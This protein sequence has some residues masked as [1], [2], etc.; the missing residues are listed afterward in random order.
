LRQTYWKD[1]GIVDLRISDGGIA[2]FAVPSKPE[3]WTETA[4]ALFSNNQFSDAFDGYQKAHMYREAAIAHAHHLEQESRQIPHRRASHRIR[5]FVKA[6]EAFL[7]CASGQTS[8]DE[9]T[10]FLRRAGQCFV[11][12]KKHDLAAKAY[13]DALMF[14]EAVS[15]Y[16]LAHML[17]KAMAIIRARRD[18]IKDDIAEGVIETARYAWTSDQKFEYVQDTF[19]V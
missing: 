17:D 13:A 14:T 3:D 8:P 19:V 4:E 18:S 12:A 9:R 7:A 1:K 16:R 2:E 11:E 10:V 15:Q 5:A 6:A